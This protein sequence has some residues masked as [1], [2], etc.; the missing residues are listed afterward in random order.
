MLIVLKPDRATIVPEKREELT[1]EGGL[2][3]VADLNKIKKVIESLKSNQISVSLFI[4]AN[5][6][7]IKA[8]LDSGADMVEFHTGKYAELSGEMARDELGRIKNACVFAKELGLRVA[9]GHGL[10]YKNTN[11]F[12]VD[13]PALEELNIGHS[14]VAR[15][16]AV[17]MQKA[18][19]EMKK[20]VNSE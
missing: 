10:N 2:N 13:M 8:S 12:V 1:T 6:E 9:A 16:F 3:V 4:E 17:G 15:A 19:E 5:D 20:A 14:I 18:V 11:Q 7:Q